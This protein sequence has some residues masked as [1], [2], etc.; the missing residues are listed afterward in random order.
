MEDGP[1]S[2]FSGF[3]ESGSVFD[4]FVGPVEVGS[5]VEVLYLH[6][7]HGQALT[8]RRIRHGRCRSRSRKGHD[9]QHPQSST[10]FQWHS[11]SP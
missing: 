3:R 2:L 5:S 9:Y 10:G 7:T 11:R 4:V 6:P 1:S 8:R